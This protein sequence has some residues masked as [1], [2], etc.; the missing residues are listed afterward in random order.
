M[1]EKQR[2]FISR[3]CPELFHSIAHSNDI[4][5][6]DP[7][8][9]LSIHQDAREVF[10]HL[11]EQALT[12]SIASGRILLIRGEAGAGKTHLMRAFRNTVHQGE[13]AF[14]AYMQMT[15]SSLNYE[16]YILQNVINSLQQPY[17]PAERRTSLQ[18]LSDRL[19][20]LLPS[21]RVEALRD[22]E[23][24]PSAASIVHELTDRLIDRNDLPPVDPDL[25]RALLFLQLGRPSVTTKVNKY[26]R[27]ES[28]SD[29]DC[30]ALG[31][32]A[33]SN[34]DD[35]P[36]TRVV[37][38]AR[39][40]R[41]PLNRALVICLDQLEDIFNLESAKERFPRAMTAVTSVAELPSVVVV[42]SC[43]EQFYLQ[44]REHMTLSTR[45]RLEQDPPPVVLSGM[46]TKTETEALISRRL[47]R[48]WQESNIE[49]QD[50]GS[51]E[52][53][54]DT[55]VER[56]SGQHSRAILSA[57]L[58]FRTRAIEQGAIPIDDT[59]TE[60]LT[61]TPTA[62]MET[63]PPL[64]T[65]LAQM[66]NDT[67]TEPQ[68][69][70]EEESDRRRLL[71][72]LLPL[73]HPELG[74]LHPLRTEHHADN[75]MTLDAEWFPA[76]YVAITESVPQGGRLLRQ[77]KTAQTNA[78]HRT[79]VLVRSDVIVRSPRSQTARFHG[80]V[81]AQG[82]RSVIVSDSDWR[83]LVAFLQ[84]HRDHHQH[85]DYETFQRTEK[86]L[87]SL[88]CIQELLDRDEL[89]IP[90]PEQV[91][92]PTESVPSP[93]SVA[94]PV[95]PVTGPAPA[96]PVLTTTA[97]EAQA[98]SPSSSTDVTAPSFDDPLDLG[99]TQG[100]RSVPITLK[101]EQFRRHAAF[102]G[103]T[104]SGKTTAAM[105]VIEQLL[106]RRI[107]AILV[108][109]KGDL[110]GY[111]LSEV[112]TSE[113]DD[114]RRT[115][116]RAQVRKNIDIQVFTPG[117]LAGR[118]L[119][120][121]LVPD[122][123]AEL[124]SYEQDAAARTAAE[125][126]AAMMNYRRNQK[127]NGGRVAIA[128]AIAY[129]A[130]MGAKPT[131]DA[132]IELL[133]QPDDEYIG[134]VGNLAKFCDG[135]AIDLDIL[136]SD[137]AILLGNDSETL[138]IDAMLQPR[139]DGRV[140]L[141]IISTKFLR[142]ESD[143][144][145]WVAQLLVH[146]NRWLDKHPSNRLQGVIL[147]DEADLY[148]PATSTPVSKKPVEDLLRRARSKGF[149][150]MLAT[151]S[152]GD[153]DYKCRDNIVSWLVGLISQP[154]ALRKLEPMF[155]ESRADTS[156]LASQSVGQFHFLFEGNVRSI[157]T[158]MNAVPLPSQVADD[159]ILRLAQEHLT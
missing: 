75:G 9:V 8:D 124:P 1:N 155:Q 48:L 61:S 85:P 128:K 10:G 108:D 116:L 57:C 112:W 77:M 91:V 140:P 26:L 101:A 30:E 40:I 109:R 66:W 4:W 131:L 7:F 151:Q 107:P 32:I 64:S 144:Q 18:V 106:A 110:C 25:I 58:M 42:V 86:P 62:V 70:P 102:L 100:L 96:A 156:R 50:D 31:G 111:G 121:P 27:A 143:I 37:N 105:M 3:K 69:V 23:T 83:A 139:P 126:L 5:L 35:G 38:L 65:E 76:T 136:R 119:S 47:D 153:L 67:R 11:V 81:I 24:G 36:L 141:S 59:M 145:F 147:L 22:A 117:A 137:N 49:T 152:P 125:G 71:A 89:K 84:F 34:L 92:S 16:R 97:S 20:D 127:H 135:T 52:P 114:K 87:T 44:A 115:T 2:A 33:P 88:S 95:T 41:T 73:V 93:N 21:R 53:F 122:D 142:S 149:G 56:I 39:L 80:R 157:K 15:T 159:T 158:H 68:E 104:G 17:H 51:V 103:S 94:D 55:F 54:P 79:L 154:T 146:I 78:K 43:L 46:R 148:L 13:N 6:P 133:Q 45:H 130:S 60:G 123:L 98:E 82:G 90:D 63:P 113:L 118:N 129:L 120:V 12:G 14:F 19:T 28:L 99:L 150:V 72:S 134:M 74:A 29:Y 138:N 132:L